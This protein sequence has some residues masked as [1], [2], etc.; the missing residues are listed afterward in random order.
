MYKKGKQ[1]L[2]EENTLQKYVDTTT[3]ELEEVVSFGIEILRMG[4]LTSA[5]R[6]SSLLFAGA[7]QS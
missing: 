4:V 7:M 1:Y 2:H 6:S 5:K 3:H